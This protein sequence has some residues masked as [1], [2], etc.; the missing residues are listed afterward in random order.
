[1]KKKFL[2]ALSRTRATALGCFLLASGI[3]ASSSKVNGQEQ[4]QPAV[5][6]SSAEPAASGSASSPSKKIFSS[7]LA[8]RTSVSIGDRVVVTYTAKLPPGA[9]LTLDSLV[10]PAPEEGERPAGGAVL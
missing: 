2:L 4:T 8:D 6:S 5:A 3:G 1:M 10:T 7:A 9:T